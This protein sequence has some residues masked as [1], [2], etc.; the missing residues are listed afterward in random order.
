[1][2]NQ[3][4]TTEKLFRVGDLVQVP[5]RHP[6]VGEIIEDRG[7]IGRG[8]RRLYGI[9]I[10]SESEEPFVFELAG[11]DLQ[12]A[13]PENPSVDKAKRIEYLKNVGLIAIL[14]AGRGGRDQPKVWLCKDSL[15]N[16]IHTFVE[17]RGN[18][19]GKTIPIGALDERK[20]IFTPKAAEVAE[21][22]QSFDLDRA[23]ADAIIRH[24]GTSP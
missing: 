4:A 5:W 3:S 15:G 10:P 11:E 8:G 22:L 18:M 21:F 12:L 20:H 9:Q 6:I 13:E 19:G 1:M 14:E 24:V 7:P 16:V 23:E 2:T 17:G